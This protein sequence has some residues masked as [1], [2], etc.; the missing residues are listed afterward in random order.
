MLVAFR[1]ESGFALRLFY[2]SRQKFVEAGFTE[3]LLHR[4]DAQQLPLI[5]VEARVA[6]RLDDGSFIGVPA[7][8]AAFDQLPA[9][10]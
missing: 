1:Y 8:G 10:V 3:Q 5:R 2:V 6:D 7:V 4:G 9:D